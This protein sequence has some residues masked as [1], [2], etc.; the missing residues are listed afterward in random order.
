MTQ[1][2]PPP[3]RADENR[4]GVIVGVIVL[5]IAIILAL[6]FLPP[7]LNPEPAATATP[8][9]VD[10]ITTPGADDIL[11]TPDGTDVG[12]DLDDE[13][14]PLADEPTVTPAAGG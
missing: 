2:T 1:Q 14:P 4:T 13:E 5:V 7:L 12:T 3:R 8:G 10:P 6:I 11:L 9:V